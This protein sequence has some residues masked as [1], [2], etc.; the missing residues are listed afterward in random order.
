VPT[1]EQLRRIWERLP[2]TQRATI[3]MIGIALVAII[4]FVGTWASRTEYA[5]LYGNLDPEDAGAVTEELR[6]QNVAYKLGNGGRTVLVPNDKVYDTRLT[7]ASAGLPNNNSQGYELLDTSKLGWT[8]FVQKLQFRRALEGEI[9]RTIQSLDAVQAAR[10]HIVMPEPSLFV[11]ETRQPTASIMV[12]VRPGASLREAEVRGIVHLVASSV[13]GLQ[14]GQV[15]VI[16]T[17]GRLL[18]SPQDPND[19]LGSSSDQLTLARSIEE[20]LARKAQSALEQVL[21]PNRAVVRV[22]AEIDLERAERTR[23][24]YDGENP[25][26]R[27]EQR[28]QQE[29]ADAGTSESATTNYEISKT[30]ERIVDTPG[31]IRRLTASVFVDGSYQVAP[32]G[33]R[34]YVPR[35]A[36]EM[37]KLTS[38]IKNV[39][40]YSA[41]RGDELS[42][43]NLPFDDTEAERAREALEKTQ[44][45]D[46]L[47]EIAGTALPALI[48][49][50]ALG[51]LWRMVSRAR[52]GFALAQTAALTE[53]ELEPTRALLPR[54]GEE[55]LRMEK[56]LRQVSQESPETIARVVRAWL[57]E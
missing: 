35:S 6:S 19:L 24:I 45:F 12:K 22:A 51:L 26:V 46:K 8:D 2:G 47:R 48:G 37:Q 34:T 52:S 42:V 40:G 4:I 30:I 5:V 10:V 57:T 39:I 28:S 33:E 44:G 15:T 36:E 32:T 17:S 56:R 20:G 3:V 14:P 7:L 27:S 53:G 31:S 9:G 41:D 13:E 29:T 11:E 1:L 55:A 38:L 49:L 54:K 43:E 18:S 25:V 16:D 23:E 50:G 21:G